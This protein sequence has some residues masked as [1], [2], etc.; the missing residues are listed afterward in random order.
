MPVFTKLKTEPVSSVY[1]HLSNGGVT[2]SVTD[3]FGPTLVIKTASF[4]NLVHTFTAHTDHRSLIALRDML[5]VAI[6]KTDYSE[7]YCHAVELIEESTFT[8]NASDDG[9]Q[10]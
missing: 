2:F 9:N 1:L 8:G 7:P 6:E 10:G 4:G 3:E 5:N